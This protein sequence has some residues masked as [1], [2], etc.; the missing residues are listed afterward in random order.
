VGIMAR[1]KLSLQRLKAWYRYTKNKRFLERHNCENWRQYRYHNDPDYNLQAS[2]V[3]DK[4]HGY[5]YV[6]RFADHKHEVYY[7]DVA[8]DG[9][10]VLSRWCDRHL[11]DKYRF[12][13]LRV[14]RDPYDEWC[15]SVIGEGDFVF[16][17]FKNQ[18][19]YTHFVLRWS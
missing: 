13:M 15:E 3:R 1:M 14:M 10:Y 6:H 5:P 2:R 8:Y 18:Q 7:W 17:G 9:I 11:K 19:D 16:V 4:F 12:D